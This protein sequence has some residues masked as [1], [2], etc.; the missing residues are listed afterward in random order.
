MWA[1]LCAALLV[2]ALAPPVLAAE[3]GEEEP[4]L[5]IRELRQVE[6]LSDSEGGKAFA[7]L[8]RIDV[9]ARGLFRLRAARMVIWLHPDADTAIF[10][11][12]KGAHAKDAGIPLWAVRGIYAEGGRVPAV[13][14]TAGRSFRCRSAYYDF[15]RHRGVIL[16]AELRLRRQ[17]RP[18]TP[19]LV[20]RARKFRATA[21]GE[22]RARDVA[23][24]AS[25]Y[26]DP[27][28]RIDVR[29]IVLRDAGMRAALGEL[30][31]ISARNYREGRGPTPAEIDEVVQRLE[32]AATAVDPKTVS[33]YGLTGRAWGVPFFHWRDME[34]RGDQLLPLRLELELGN[35]DSLGNGGRFGI[36]IRHEPLSWLFGA[37]YYEG[38]GPL[39]DLETE[40]STE[41]VTGRSFSVYMHDRGMDNG[42]APSTRDRYWFQHQYRWEIN[43]HWRLDG[44]WADLSDSRW[45]R[46][47]DEREFKEGKEQET[48]LYLRR[49]DD[50]T[51]VT[52]T[53]KVRTIGF[54][55]V[56]EEMPRLVAT[57]PALT[58]L[59][60]GESARGEPVTLQLA[61]RLEVSNLRWRD[62]DGGTLGDF[63]TGRFDLDPTL[64]LSFDVG[65]VR[66]VP[67]AEFRLTG[68]EQAL[69]GDAV[70][71]FAGTAG[72]RTDL[73]LSR[74][75]GSLRH[76]M[77]IAVEYANLYS[78]S[79]LAS[80]FF[81][82]DDT[83]LVS[84]YQ[85]VG[86]RWRH[87]L[88]RREREGGLREFLSF[89]IYAAWFPGRKQPLGRMGDGFIETDLEWSPRSNLHFSARTEVDPE[90]GTLDTGSL[91]TRWDPRSYFTVIGS[92]RH[93]E[94]D[95]DILTLSGDYM[96][97]DRWRLVGVAQVDFKGGEGLDHALV[98]ERIGKTVVV[99]LRF[100]WDP[101]DNNFGFSVKLNLLEKFR[102]K[103]ERRVRRPDIRYGNAWR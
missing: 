35:R 23:V 19:D 59:R 31:R 11:V 72:V 39:F 5:S 94:G 68:Y 34:I 33:L 46:T 65:P 77:N 70:A 49:R 10:K 89:E 41:R 48:L 64:Y 95:S 90:R 92:V 7:L 4:I 53:G 66:V 2:L 87:R 40:L 14:Q 3:P 75:Y 38:R 93:L 25:N 101:G 22:W 99:G 73:Q 15:V 69:D 96:V 54:A 28:V 83:D 97:G 98:V 100:R 9:E 8:G 12:V 56:I 27:E 36:G 88:Q 32:D 86:V 13:F 1:R 58:L 43:D 76:V 78:L 91:E 82:M 57:L 79:D 51:Y 62:G 17:I 42:L 60:L 29:R 81:A 74:W 102:K 44:E 20:L 61:G 24:F 80:A 67:F 30:T 45:L 26:Q 63:R 85:S 21:P 37:G 71:R 52:L 6:E 16:D 103:Q 55:T 50:L 84:R 47:Y 18:G